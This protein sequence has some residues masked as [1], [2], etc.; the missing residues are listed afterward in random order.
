MHT[1]MGFKIIENPFLTKT[2][3]DWSKVRSPGRA[4][5]RRPKHRQNIKILTVPDDNFYL[6]QG[7]MLICH[8]Y[9]A[10]KLEKQAQENNAAPFQPVAQRIPKPSRVFGSGWSEAFGFT[11]REE[12]IQGGM[13]RTNPIFRTDVV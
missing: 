2:I 6:A 4:R 5:R 1:F 10:R 7:R 8:P 13:F 3:E 11:W 12:M 9:M